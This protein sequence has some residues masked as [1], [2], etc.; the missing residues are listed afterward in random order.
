MRSFAWPLLL[1]FVPVVAPAQIDTAAG[2]GSL[3]AKPG[4]EV[5]IT[6]RVGRMFYGHLDQVTADSV[7]IRTPG[8]NDRI[9]IAAIPRDSI[10]RFEVNHRGAPHTVAGFLLGLGAGGLVGSGIAA[11]DCLIFCTAQE[12]HQANNA[13]EVGLIVGGVIGAL[14]GSAI[15]SAHWR[16]VPADRLGVTV[17]PTGGGL[18]LGLTLRF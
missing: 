9:A 15:R 7:R 14:T 2:A 4:A 6:T 3:A 13:V 16:E 10:A 12:Q 11:A 5:R 8:A 1:V 18:G 17:K